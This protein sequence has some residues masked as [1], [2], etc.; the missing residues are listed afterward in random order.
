MGDFWGERRP[1]GGVWGGEVGDQGI[2]VVWW[3][4]VWQLLMS[5]LYVGVASLMVTTQPVGMVLDFFSS[6]LIK[7]GLGEM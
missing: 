3:V 1:P 5:R 4:V 7:G 6:E 2:V